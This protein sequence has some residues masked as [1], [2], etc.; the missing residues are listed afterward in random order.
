MRVIHRIAEMFRSARGGRPARADAPAVARW[1]KRAMLS[2]LQRDLDEAA[3]EQAFI[4]AEI[5]RSKQYAARL[6]TQTAAAKAD[7]AV[8][9]A[10]QLQEEQSQTYAFLAELAEAHREV[11]TERD[12]LSALAA[13]LADG[14]AELDATA[15][16]TAAGSAGELR[17]APGPTA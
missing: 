14:L 2:S 11:V 15:S 13:R 12:R 4:E 10:R 7:G 16:T 3:D 5:A 6:D 17:N 8:I 9:V 1:R